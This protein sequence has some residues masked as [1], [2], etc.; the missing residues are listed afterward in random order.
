MAVR[1]QAS[2]RPVTAVAVRSN[3]HVHG[4]ATSDGCQLSHMLG[5]CLQGQHDYARDATVDAACTAAS[6]STGSKVQVAHSL[7]I[8]MPCVA[9]LQVGLHGSNSVAFPPAC[10]IAAWNPRLLSLAILPLW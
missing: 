9:F 5:G 7:Q 8:N 2:M 6:Q 4:W 3:K 1:M 10:I